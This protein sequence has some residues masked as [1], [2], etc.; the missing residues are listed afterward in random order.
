MSHHT[1]PPLAP[2]AA[3]ITSHNPQNIAGLERSRPAISGGDA[4]SSVVGTVS[5]AAVPSGATDG[6]DAPVATTGSPSAVAV[7]LG[8]PPELGAAVVVSV[9]S[10]SAADGGAG[11]AVGAMG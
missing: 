10:T 2:T 9:V 5:S 1:N 6:A 7:T 4:V 11:V 3:T 8:T